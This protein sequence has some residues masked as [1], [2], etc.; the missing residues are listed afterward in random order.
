[1]S[2]TDYSTY[3]RIDDLLRLQQP[4]TPGA[5]DELLFIVVHQVYELWFALL[6]H[7]LERARDALL[8]GRPMDAV[9]PLRRALRV[10]DLAV[11]QLRLLETMSPDGFMEFRDPLKPASGFQSFQFRAI[12]ALC[13]LGDA[14]RLDDPGWTDEH[15]DLVRRRLEAPTLEVGLR[16]ACDAAG[17]PMP[18]DDAGVRM[19]SLVALYRDHA[20]PG[21]A[22]LHLVCELLLDHDE[23]LARWRHHHVLMA[24]REIGEREG[25]GGSAGV[26]YLSTTLGKRC[27]PELWAVRSRL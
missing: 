9:M 24:A 12:E 22:A 1:V 17:L 25:T 19:E 5:P 7:E 4:L 8:D 23:A 6:L 11:D 10:D 18:D 15:R 13:G 16:R 2:D 26:R 3:L 14:S 27:F 20:T 21:R